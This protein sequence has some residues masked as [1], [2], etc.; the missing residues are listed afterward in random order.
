MNDIW[1]SLGLGI[2]WYGRL[3]T[4]CPE[5]L[6]DPEIY[7]TALWQEW[8]VCVKLKN[9]QMRPEMCQK[10]LVNVY[11]CFEMRILSM[12]WSE[13]IPR[14]ARPLCPGS[15]PWPAIEIAHELGSESLERQLS[16]WPRR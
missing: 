4:E 1:A 15:R 6:P 16:R 3:V 14:M 13:D 9:I 2:A 11:F 5:V 12:E 8:L 10:S 7:R